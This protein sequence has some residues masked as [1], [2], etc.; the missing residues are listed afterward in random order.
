[1]T[2]DSLCLN[3][4]LIL[5]V[6]IISYH[7]LIVRKAEEPLEVGGPSGAGSAV[8]SLYLG[9]FQ[10]KKVSYGLQD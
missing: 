4:S 3:R 2:P 9:T 5:W 6:S 7:L 10:N 8:L 1:M